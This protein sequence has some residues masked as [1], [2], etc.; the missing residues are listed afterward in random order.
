MYSNGKIAKNILFNIF[1]KFLNTLYEV[2]KV[3]KTFFLVENYK[4]ISEES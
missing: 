2:L 3:S 4:V 1:K